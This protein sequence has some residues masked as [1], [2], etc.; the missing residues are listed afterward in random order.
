L[1]LTHLC[2]AGCPVWISTRRDTACLRLCPISDLRASCF[3]GLWLMSVGVVVAFFTLQ[4]IT[5]QYPTS[6]WA[7]KGRPVAVSDYGHHPVAL[8]HEIGLTGTDLAWQTVSVA[9]CQRVD[10]CGTARVSLCPACGSAALY[11]ARLWLT[12]HGWDTLTIHYNI[13]FCLPVWEPRRWK[14][15][16]GRPIT[17]S[18]WSQLSQGL[19]GVRIGLAGTHPAWHGARVDIVLPTECNY[20]FV[21]K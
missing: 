13:M 3:V 11:S 5:P 2:M 16:C 9:D 4:N 10:S 20:K 7:D 15:D 17:V 21:S 18:D 8:S 6:S 19:W 1:A 12:N 14:L